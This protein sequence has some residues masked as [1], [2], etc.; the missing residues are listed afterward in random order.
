[1]L[2]DQKALQA[3]LVA[4][5]ALTSGP[6]DHYAHRKTSKSVTFPHEIP[7]KFLR[8]ITESVFKEE[9]WKPCLKN[10]VQVLQLK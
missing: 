6:W 3:T 10:F 9:K 1:M 7:L 8:V 4:G 2:Q 5:R